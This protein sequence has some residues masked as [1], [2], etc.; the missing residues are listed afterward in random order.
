[1]G[2]R[3][4]SLAVDGSQVVL[5]RQLRGES[6]PCP[7]DIRRRVLFECGLLLLV[8]EVMQS[9]SRLPSEV[10][11]DGVFKGMKL[12]LDEIF[13]GEEHGSQSLS[14]QNN[15]LGAVPNSSRHHM[16]RLHHGDELGTS[17]IRRGDC[18]RCNLGYVGR[19]G[20]RDD[21]LDRQVVWIR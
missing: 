10:A 7:L 20:F 9:L 8:E 5:S 21:Q 17:E 11:Y 14:L 12:L 16:K 2:S 19:Q 4:S 1:M 18:I 3:P 13:G 15:V 6:L